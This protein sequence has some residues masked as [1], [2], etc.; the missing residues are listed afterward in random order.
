MPISVELS[1]FLLGHATTVQCV[2]KLGE[3]NFHNFF[4]TSLYFL[5]LYDDFCLS[6]SDDN[7]VS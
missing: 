7:V 1:N 6:S 5:M 2:P 3:I 4:V